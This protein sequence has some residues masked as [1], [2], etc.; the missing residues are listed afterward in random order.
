MCFLSPPYVHGNVNVLLT[1]FA[2]MEKQRRGERVNR[3]RRRPGLTDFI[4]ELERQT[5]ETFFENNLIDYARVRWPKLNRSRT[6]RTRRYTLRL[7]TCGL[8]SGAW[9][10]PFSSIRYVI[11]VQF[12]R[13]TRPTPHTTLTSPLVVARPISAKIA[14]ID[15]RDDPSELFLP[16]TGS[17]RHGSSA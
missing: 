1:S 6:T 9:S 16:A 12:V 15:S 8:T 2:L 3:R 14:S 5:S 7:S 13:Q 11:S 17:G 4:A 10:F